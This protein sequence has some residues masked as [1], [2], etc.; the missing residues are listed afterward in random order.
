MS[1]YE[2]L[3]L[4]MI[5]FDFIHGW[6][7]YRKIRLLETKVLNMTI[8]HDEFSS[9]VFWNAKFPDEGGQSD[10]DYCSKEVSEKWSKFH[11]LDS[12][13]HS[14]RRGGK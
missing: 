5:V 7:T 8:A 4:G 3:I 2:W 11:K 10:G 12:A 1:F 14:A 9:Y 13:F 6:F